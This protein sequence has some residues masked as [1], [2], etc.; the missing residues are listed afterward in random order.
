MTTSHSEPPLTFARVDKAIL[1]YEHSKMDVTYMRALHHKKLTS[2]L[3]RTA[4]LKLIRDEL[5]KAWCA[6]GGED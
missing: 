4:G 1:D 3:V 5:I 2:L 6:N